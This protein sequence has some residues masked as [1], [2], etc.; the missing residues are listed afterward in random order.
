MPN[1]TDARPE[2]T[3]VLWVNPVHTPAYDSAIADNLG[4][5]AGP[6]ATV[7]VLSFDPPGPTHLEYAAHGAAVGPALL[8]AVRWARRDGYDA[9]CIGCFYDPGLRAARELAGTM[10]VTAPAEACLHTATVLGSRVSVLVANRTCT[11][12]AREAV[13]RTGLG[14]R[15]VSYRSLDMRV[16]DFQQTPE[17]TRNRMLDQARIATESDGADVVVLG[18]TLEYGL[19]ESVQRE[20]GVPVLDATSTPLTFAEYLV[21]LGRRCGSYASRLDYQ[22][23]PD[24]ELGW[25]PPGDPP[26]PLL[27]STYAM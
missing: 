2:P 12:E 19:G 6:G 18:C 1:S 15:V 7:D 4:A 26:G 14:G 11:A 16:H 8:A 20:L 21:S 27:R 23:P 3:R 5:L 10:V 25:L 17:L 9:L 22:S 24:S 13:E